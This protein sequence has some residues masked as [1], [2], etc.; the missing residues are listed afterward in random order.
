MD[1]RSIGPDCD[2]GTLQCAGIAERWARHLET[3]RS[4]GSEILL[5]GRPV[6]AGGQVGARRRM[7]E[8]GDV[9]AFLAK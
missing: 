1:W 8:R 9:A 7:I 6:L 4:D 2:H 5:D 3:F